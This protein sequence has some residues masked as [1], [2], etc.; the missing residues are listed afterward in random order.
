MYTP[1]GIEKAVRTSRKSPAEI[2]Y[3]GS[4]SLLKRDELTDTSINAFNDN[5]HSLID[6]KHN[7]EIGIQA[8]SRKTVRRL[9]F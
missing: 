8:S 4:L 1:E 6:R 9:D 3:I 5:F 7:N 2:E